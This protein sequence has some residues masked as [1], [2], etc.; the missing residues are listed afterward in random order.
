MIVKVIFIV[1]CCQEVLSY[2]EILRAEFPNAELK[3]SRLEEF[4]EAAEV[5]RDKL[6]VFTNEVGDTWIE[7]VAS[8]PRKCAE[9]RAV[10]RVMKT[11][12]STG[13]CN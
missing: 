1:I 6:P 4:F 10:S 8:D 3:A 13:K 5:I 2:Y 9:Y 11:C 7:G 12:F